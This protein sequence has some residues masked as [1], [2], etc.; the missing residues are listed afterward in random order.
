[1]GSSVLAPD[2]CTKENDRMGDKYTWL[3]YVG[4]A[5]LAWGTYVPLIAYGGSQLTGKPG[6]GS[7]MAILCVGIAYFVI[8]VIFPLAMFLSGQY[9]WPTMKATGL[10]FAG[11]AGVAGAVGALC[12]V[13]ATVGARQA[14]VAHGALYIAPIIF[15][16]APLINTLVSTFWQ[17]KPGQPFEFGVLVPGWK[18]WLGIVLVGIGAWLVLYSKEEAK[19]AATSHAPA[20]VAK[21]T[22]A[23]PGT[24]DPGAK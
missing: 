12:V 20:A 8:A 22:P 6:S 11:L 3:L 23:A 9:E 5:G 17:P 16:L 14:G 7:L 13:F 2:Q 10:V 1:M 21:A 24:T 15:A 4:L 18:L 19:E